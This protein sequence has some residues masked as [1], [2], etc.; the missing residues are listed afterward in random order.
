MALLGPQLSSSPNESTIRHAQ[1]VPDLVA[2]WDFESTPVPRWRRRQVVETLLR[3]GHRRPKWFA[4]RPLT[5]RQAWAVFFLYAPQGEITPAQKF[6]LSRLKDLGLNLLVICASDSA[7][8][9]PNDLYTYAD[10]L[11]WKSVEG[12]DFSAYTLALLEISKL[13]PGADVFLMNDSVFGPFSDLN[14]ML[15]G[16]PWDLTGFTASSQVAHHVQSYAFALRGVDRMRMLNLAPVF[17]PFLALSDPRDVVNIQEIRLAR[18]AARS[19]KVGAFWF[20]DVKKVIDPTLVR[21][22]EL[23]NVGFPFLK[24]SLL[25]K[26]KKFQD[27]ELVLSHLRD[28]G[29]PV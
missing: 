21:P 27:E 8:L 19:M 28:Q 24:R 13:A 17:F 25:G 26:H 15:R 20:G 7:S 5:K 2:N 18:V 4:V 10:A 14:E 6:T 12:Y 29:H 16:A 22:F 23:L 9:L 3:R 11:F 1:T